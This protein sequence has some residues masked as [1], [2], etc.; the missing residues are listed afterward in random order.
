MKKTF[1]PNWYIDKKNHIRNKKIKIYI[2]IIFIINIL[3]LS[4]ILNT[5]NKIKN[6]EGEISN[7]KKNSIVAKNII[8]A[9]NVRG[10]EMIKHDITTIEK[11]KEF[12]NF[13]VENNINYKNIIITK[14][15]LEVDMEVKTYEEYL[16][17]IKCLENHFSIKKLTPNNKD[18]GNFNFKVILEV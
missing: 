8:D 9:E 14:G 13:F 3:L 2:L 5:S 4:A 17:V 7:Q 18:E 1:V 6:I 11:Y 12:S 16:G 10:I 15:N